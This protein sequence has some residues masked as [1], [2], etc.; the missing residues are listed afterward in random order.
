MDEAIYLGAEL[1]RLGM[2]R[3]GLVVNRTHPWDPAG[4]DVRRTTDRLTGTLGGRLAAKVA[5]QHAQLQQLADEEGNALTRLQRALPDT[6]A[7]HLPDRGE[8][9]HDVAS[10]VELQD[11]LF[12]VECRT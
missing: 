10:L 9:V 3:A 5:G 6:S 2:H 8:D 4:A 7:R 1:D 12:G 11:E